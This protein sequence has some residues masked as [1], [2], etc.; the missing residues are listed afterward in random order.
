MKV[1]LDVDGVLIGKD[2]SAAMYVEEFLEALLDNHDCYWL[3]THC[4][5][6][7][8]GVIH[9][10]RGYFHGGLLNHLSSIKPTKWKTLKTDAIDFQ[11][12]FRWFDD[13]VMEAE[14]A[15]LE[16]NNCQAKIV[17]ID[18]KKNPEQLKAFTGEL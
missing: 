1:Y 9:Y 7:T 6:D 8:K 12:D 10:L 4:Q 15:V 13:Y 5:G 2:G 3:T 18:L 16:Q 11:S 14:L 17:T